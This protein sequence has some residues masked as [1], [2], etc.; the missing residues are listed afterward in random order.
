MLNFNHTDITFTLVIGEFNNCVVH[1]AGIGLTAMKT[2]ASFLANFYA[3]IGSSSDTAKKLIDQFEKKG[4]SVEQAKLMAVWED[5]RIASICSAMSN[6]TILKANIQAAVNKTKLSMTDK[7]LLDRHARLT[8]AEYCTGC[9]KICESAMNYQVPICDILRYHM[10]FHIYD[11]QDEAKKLFSKL[12][13]D[14]KQKIPSI[15]YVPA[16]KKCPQQIAIGKFMRESYN[17]LS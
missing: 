15:N 17:K 6:M 16:E 10:Y 13:F 4:Y 7:Q 12:P 8:I 3:S 5:S 2:Q 14:L 1:K 9:A 11:K